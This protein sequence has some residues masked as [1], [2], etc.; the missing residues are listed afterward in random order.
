MR[1]ETVKVLDNLFEKQDVNQDKANTNNGVIAKLLDEY[2]EFLGMYN[3]GNGSIGEYSYVQLWTFEDI[4]ELN[5]NYEV[6]EF[7]SGIVLIGSDGGDTAYGI[8]EF[9]KYIEVPFIGMDNDE[10][11]EIASNFDEFIEYLFN[12]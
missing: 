10:V 3:G 7:L 1:A 9:G 4:V 6:D 11:Q 8:N 5:R 12:K 2:K